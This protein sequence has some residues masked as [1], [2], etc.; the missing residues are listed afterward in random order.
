[1][2]RDCS[3]N[4]INLYTE[5]LEYHQHLNTQEFGVY[6][7]LGLVAKSRVPQKTRDNEHFN[8]S[9]LLF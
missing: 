5:N 6:D 8:I 2:K 9:P 3:I 7:P 1:M 4:E